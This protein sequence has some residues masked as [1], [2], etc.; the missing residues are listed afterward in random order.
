MAGFCWHMRSMHMLWPALAAAG[1]NICMSIACAC[2]AVHPVGQASIETK[3]KL[4]MASLTYSGSCMRHRLAQTDQV[5]ARSLTKKQPSW[6][7]TPHHVPCPCCRIYSALADSS[8]VFEVEAVGSSGIAGNSAS[9]PFIVDTTGPTFGN[10]TFRQIVSGTDAST[11][12]TAA[13]Y[14]V[15]VLGNNF[16]ITAP[17]SDGVLGSGVNS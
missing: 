17:A 6:L 2:P 14:L 1:A 9:Y 15:K 16:A 7:T 3:A 13:G 5:L 4:P 10:V 11:T 8:Y 12:L